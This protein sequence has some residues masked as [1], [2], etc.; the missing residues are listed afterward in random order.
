MRVLLILYIILILSFSA[1]TQTENE[2]GSLFI[3]NYS[4]K[5]YEGSSQNWSIVQ[6]K[7][8]ILYFGN[9]NGS[10]LQFDGI[11]WDAMLS[12]YFPERLK[13][14]YQMAEDE[15]GNIWVAPENT[16][17]QSMGFLKPNETDKKYKWIEEPFLRLP[18]MDVYVL[19]PEKN[20][21][22]W[23]GGTEGL[24]RVYE[25]S[26]LS[27]EISGYPAL[28]RRVILNGDSVLFNGA[29]PGKNEQKSLIA[30]SQPE[31]YILDFSPQQN[32]IMFEVSSPLFDNP[33]SREFQYFLEGYDKEWSGW[34]DH[35]F[36][37]YTNIPGGEYT[38]KVRV[39]DVSNVLSKVD[40]YRFRV[41]TAWY[42]TVWAFVLYIILFA[43]IIWS[44]IK[45]NMRRLKLANT[46]LE[47]LVNERTREIKTQKEE[48]L[49]QKNE[50]EAQRDYTV[51]QK[52]HIEKQNKE[53]EEHRNHLEKLVEQRTKDLK[54][55]K[56]KAEEA[57]RLKSVFL[58]NMS[59]EIRTPMNAILGFSNLLNDK[60]LD[61]NLKNELITQINIHSNSLL[62]LIDNI[63]DLARIDSEQLQIETKECP[64][65]EIVDELYDFF[66]DNV[67]YKNISLL[68]TKEKK[69]VDFKLYSDP[70]R[71]R[72]I[73]NNLIDNAVKFTDQGS[74]EFGYEIIQKDDRNYIRFFVEDTGIG[75]T[76]KQK[77][78]IFDRFTKIED[79][80]EKFYRG[81]GLGLTIS[82]RLVDMLGGTIWLKSIPHE[83]SIF[84]FSLP[85]Q[86]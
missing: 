2:R 59:H 33:E 25:R 64:V 45:L 16:H 6:D 49:A 22:T 82:K 8:G 19:F 21:V 7:R 62:N 27:K 56:E 71:I 61:N 70:Y 52:E 81:A 37:E 77:D 40:E 12:Q 57:N 58:A 4:P 55:A 31:Q 34:V 11:N 35:P 18:Y 1:F 42:K 74:V 26:S 72:Q 32:D 9:A 3:T 15:N 66:L 68:T 5:T 86:P 20:Q 17:G 79:D 30:T 80:K 50:I 76:K 69:G 44:L 84:Y 83:G 13:Y 73:L 51:K 78:V 28:I 65:D 75:I 47:K 46:K 54:E 38:F 85:L 60:E 63:I 41:Q 53:L 39:K 29:Y 36:K 48:M 14:I 10:V 67:V 24:F 43:L 23:I